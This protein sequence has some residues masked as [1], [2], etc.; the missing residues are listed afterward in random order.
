MPSPAAVYQVYSAGADTTNL[1]TPVL[2]PTPVNGDVIVVKM[3]TWD[4]GNGMGA[5]SGGAQTY[6]VIN[7][8]APGGFN[9][10][11]QIVTCTVAGSPGAYQITGAGSAAPSRHSMIVEHYLAS[12]GAFLAGPPATNAVV[13]G[14]VS[15]PSAS[16]TTV[17]TGSILTWCSTDVASVDPS[18]R[19]Y[20]LS[21][22]EDG[23]F[24]GFVGSNSIQYFAYAAVGAPG[25]YTIGMSAPNTQRWV[26]T[27]V[28]VQF[29]APST[30]SPV[31]VVPQPRR[32]RDLRQPIIV[33]G[34]G[35]PPSPPTPA[36]VQWCA[37]TPVTGWTAQSP[38][39]D[40]E[41]DTPLTNWMVITPEED[42]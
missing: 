18:G 20:L 40:W 27:G 16:I 1:V 36:D 26:M 7:T 2:S 28:E 8:A 4:T 5:V 15:A 42:C 35:A 38:S 13:T 12:Q 21:A 22:T 33:T 6:N 41:A 29:L 32:R 10:W 17:G 25:A 3:T 14:A 23:I 34:I 24:N 19:A 39:T 31:L 9:G 37:Q 11:S 30:G